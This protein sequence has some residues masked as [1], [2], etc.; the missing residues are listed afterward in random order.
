[1]TSTAHLP[2]LID[3]LART[4]PADKDRSEAA[5]AASLAEARTLLEA[6]QPADALEAALAARAVAAHFAAMDSFARAAKPGMSDESV[7]RLRGNAIAAGRV[8][9]NLRREFR[10]LRRP[11]PAEPQPRARNQATPAIPA[12]ADLMTPGSR[13][14]DWR[15]G[16]ALVSVQPTVPVPA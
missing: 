12:L 7:I 2:L 10:R 11:A 13:R 4:V 3:A 16:T 6:W 8:F 14:A 1:M 9:D 15:S 5:R